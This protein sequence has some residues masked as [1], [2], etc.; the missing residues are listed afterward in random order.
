MAA[1][2]TLIGVAVLTTGCSLTANTSF[3]TDSTSD[4]L[5]NLSGTP[6]TAGVPEPATGLLAIVSLSLVF[7]FRQKPAKNGRHDAE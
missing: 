3:V 2:A 4:T 5:F 6:S 1:L 7:A